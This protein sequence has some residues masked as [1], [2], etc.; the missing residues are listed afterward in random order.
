MYQLF[1]KCPECDYY[2]DDI[3]KKRIRYPMPCR[4]GRSTDTYVPEVL[5][6]TECEDE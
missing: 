1:W 2:I 3:C 6:L 4:C 5:K